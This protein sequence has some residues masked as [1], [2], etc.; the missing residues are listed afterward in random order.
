MLRAITI[1]SQLQ[2]PFA[3]PTPLEEAR[4]R[5]GFVVGWEP[6][7]KLLQ[8]LSQKPCISRAY[9][10][11]QEQHLRHFCILKERRL[12]KER[13][14]VMTWDIPGRCQIDKMTQ[15]IIYHL[16]RHDTYHVWCHLND[17]SNQE[18]MSRVIEASE[19]QVEPT[20]FGWMESSQWIHRLLS[21]PGTDQWNCFQFGIIQRDSDFTFFA[22]IDHLYADG[23]FLA[24]VFEEIH[25]IYHSLVANEQPKAFPPTA[26]YLDYCRH[27]RLNSDSLTLQ[28]PGIQEWLHFLRS[29]D[30]Q[31]PRWPLEL[32][33][34]SETWQSS[35]SIVSIL[36]ALETKDFVRYC[37]NIKVPFLVGML[38]CFAFAEH[39]LTGRKEI[40]LVTPVTN[41]SSRA[42][43]RTMGW[44]TGL[45]PVS[46]TGFE[47]GIVY[48]MQRAKL[49]FN[50]R[51]QL[52][53]IPIERLVELTSEE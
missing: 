4:Y 38:S 2:Q 50:S 47:Y 49:S 6:S 7:P 14:L 39:L 3:L 20:T 43:F 35:I 25:A 29:N 36:D 45:V 42:E 34:D 22:C 48:V 21:T 51:R 40:H 31:L 11:Q 16:Q 19:I 30:G 18:E 9:S 26:S 33:A 15:T 12:E 52:A 23:Y 10:Y 41:R 17:E 46:M 28:H 44:F 37:R 27:Q 53:S 5:P 1:E 24:I 32:Q 13:L 8:S